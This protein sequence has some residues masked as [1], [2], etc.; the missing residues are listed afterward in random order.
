[1]SAMLWLYDTSD[2]VVE[3]MKPILE[4]HSIT[5]SQDVHQY[6]IGLF[7]NGTF[8]GPRWAP[9]SGLVMMYMTSH[10]GKQSE[11]TNRMTK[12]L[13]RALTYQVRLGNSTERE[14]FVYQM[15]CLAEFFPYIADISPILFGIHPLIDGCVLIYTIKE[16]R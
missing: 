12:T 16:Y 9:L 5:S 14:I 3:Y 10:T 8:S 2:F 1:F 6:V 4:C 7:W 15:P 11:K 13:M